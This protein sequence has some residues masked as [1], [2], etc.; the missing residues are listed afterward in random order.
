MPALLRLAVPALAALLLSGCAS[1]FLVDNQVESFPRWQDRAPN[2]AVPAAPQIYRFERLPSQQDERGARG[3]DELERY[4]E[5]SLAKLGWTRAATG[6]SAPWAVQVHA[7]TVRLPRA[8]WEDPW[9]RWGP[10]GSPFA[11]PG[12]D[13]VV[14]GNGQVIFF[15]AFPRMESPYYQRAVS[16]VI[17]DAASGRVVYETRGAHDGRWNSSPALWTAMLDAALQGFPAPPTG[18]RQVNIEVPR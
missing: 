4:A 14:T 11:L 3:Q 9:D 18:A 8:P 12:R 2:A 1:V 5:A 6:V 13:Y 16:L 15:P 10:Y 17:R 7:N